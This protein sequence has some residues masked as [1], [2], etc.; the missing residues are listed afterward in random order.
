MTFEEL[1]PAKVNLTLHVVGQRVD[2]YHLLDS[3]VLFAKVGDRL[4]Y[5]EDSQRLELRVFGRES[6]DVPT[7]EDNLVLQAAR[8]A[9]LQSGRFLLEKNIPSAAGIGGG[10]SD[11]AAVLRGTGK[12]T[13]SRSQSLGADV[14]VCLVG[15]AARMRGIG[16]EVTPVDNLPEL[17]AVLV[18][19][20]RPVLT[21]AVFKKLACKDGQ[22]MSEAPNSN[23]YRDFISW[24]A[25]QRN[26]LQQ[27]AIALEPEIAAVLEKLARTNADLVRMSG[28]GATCF[29]LY[30]DLVAAHDAS[31]Q[32]AMSRPDWWVVP[33][34]LT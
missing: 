17:F 24:L 28:S 30:P 8:L 21:E 23:C 16:D 14:S 18:N 9:G 26:D 4:S 32:I 31:R 10:S 19:P 22:P 1:A 3:L 25:Q 11:A 5:S 20:R 13:S 12:G 27:A 29:G 33:T 7:G 6:G 34:Q 2:G 15:R